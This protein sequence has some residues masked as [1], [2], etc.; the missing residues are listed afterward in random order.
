M[1]ESL[2][3]DAAIDEL[4]SLGRVPTERRR[5]NP[6]RRGVGECGAPGTPTRQPPAP[7]T[8]PAG[9]AR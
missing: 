6:S 9:H 8:D 4:R 3:T 5:N 1:V 2:F 7:R